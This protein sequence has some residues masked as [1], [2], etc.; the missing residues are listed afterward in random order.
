MKEGFFG[1]DE[2]PRPEYIV[3]ALKDPTNIQ[4]MQ[5]CMHKEGVDS[6]DQAYNILNCYLKSVQEMIRRQ[7]QREPKPKENDSEPKSEL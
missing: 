1:L 3:T 4:M 6:C 2:K 7:E 5:V